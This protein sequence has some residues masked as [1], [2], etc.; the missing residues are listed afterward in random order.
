MRTEQM[1]L[2]I[3]L[4][5]LVFLV[6][7][8]QDIAAE[9]ELEKTAD[10]VRSKRATS[11]GVKEYIEQVTDGTHTYE[12]RMGGALDGFNTADYPD[13][14][15]GFKRIKAK[16]EP[17]KYLVI[18]NLG[19]TDVVNPRIVVNGR[20]NWYST[21]NI[22][23]SVLKPGM[24]NA[25][26]AMAIF[27]FTSSIELRCHEND[28]RPG[29]ETPDDK[30]NPSRNTFKERANPVKAANSY[31]CSGCQYAATNFVILCRCAG[32]VARAV[33]L[34]PMDRY[35]GH[36]VAEVWYDGNWHLFDPEQNSFYL[37]SDNTTIASYETVHK[38]PSLAVRTHEGGFAATE[39]KHRGPGYKKNYPP[40]IMSVEQ[41][42]ST[43]A[44]TLRPGE[45]F[46][47][48]WNH[49]GKYRCGFNP[50]NIK[51]NRPDGLVPY[52]LANGK[53]IYRPRLAAGTAFRRGIVSEL[54]I[55]STG[56]DAQSAKLQPEVAGWPGF[57]IYKV[58]SP[59]P[60]VGGIV[61]GKFFRKTTEDTYRIYVSVHD[62]NWIE[63]WS[64]KE[65][66]EIEKHIA[67]DEVLNPKPTAA[68]YD[69]Y[70]K[71]ELQAE[72]TPTNAW[73]REAYI[74]TDVQMAATSLPSLS[75]GVNKVV[76]RDESGQGRRVRITH[77]W[78]ESSATR[79][80]L[81]PAGP[82]A[83][84]HGSEVN[85]ASLNKLTWKAAKDPDGDPIADYHI[86]VSPR[87]DMLHPLCPNFDRLTFSAKPDWNVPDGWLVKGQTYYWRVRAR[88]D[89]GAWSN[90]SRIWKFRIRE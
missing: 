45:K 46:I 76:Y 11:N 5:Y 89:W 56:A 30:S 41:W 77:G 14:Y 52:Q 18:E 44:I 16:F 83:P 84:D 88:D 31:Y 85:L 55:K 67:I 80:P 39:V 47:R 9:A 64:A 72:E 34:N 12:V 63:V 53:I 23:A 32:L 24:T 58:S 20:R 61:G 71:F 40:H 8:C 48:R 3:G 17:N 90:W 60:I 78:S 50:R 28:R 74:E 6:I 70:V 22:L 73:M 35:G 65:T 68:I 26:K 69:Y 75:A 33:W 21:D 4:S 82:V 51:P 59:Y 19:D 62:S 38:N 15:L 27:N 29:P 42:L 66:G 37:E 13:T 49:I 79:P 1:A 2:L 36:C 43:M 25:E 10:P 86:Q 81:P 87:S 7:G 54:N 57:V